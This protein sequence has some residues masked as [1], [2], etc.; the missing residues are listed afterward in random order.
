[1]S[2]LLDELAKS[3]MCE[4]EIMKV[5]ELRSWEGLSGKPTGCRPATKTNSEG[6]IRL[7]KRKDSNA[8]VMNELDEVMRII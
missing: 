8:K 4:N 2:G 6:L 7:N 3:N 5:L 1:M